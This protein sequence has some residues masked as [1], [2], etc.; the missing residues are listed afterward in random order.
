V[1]FVTHNPHHVYQVADRFVI[2]NEGKVI[3]DFEK[4]DV[5]PEKIIELICG[6]REKKDCP[7][8]MLG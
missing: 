1:I 6:Q 2:L 5:T 8:G 4:K 3:G 7:E